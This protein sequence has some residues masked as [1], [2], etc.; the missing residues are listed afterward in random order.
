[1]ASMPAFIPDARA[2]MEDAKR[3]AEAIVGKDAGAAEDAYWISSARSLIEG[4]ILHTVITR[5]I[6]RN[7]G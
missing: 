2:Q 6:A 3:I 4:I 7:R 1:M 5:R